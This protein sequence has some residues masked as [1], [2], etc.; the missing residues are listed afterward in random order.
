MQPPL[1]DSRDMSA[2]IQQMKEMAPYYTPEWRFTLEDPD[3]GSALFL[4]FAD[5][6]MG[7]INRLNQVP[8]KN[9][10]AFM[11]RFD[12]S[13]LTAKPASAYLTFTLSEGSRDAVLIPKGTQVS[14]QPDDGSEDEIIFETEK[15]VMITPAVLQD[16]YNV[17]TLSD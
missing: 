11:N 12:V 8:M 2:L 4:L 1:I 16:T 10:I 3:P 9:F 13:L 17:S 15:V 14:A 6:F 5:L 7:N